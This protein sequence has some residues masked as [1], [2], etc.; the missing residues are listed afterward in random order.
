[1]PTQYWC[2]DDGIWNCPEGSDEANC[3]KVRKTMKANSVKESAGKFEDKPFKGQNWQKVREMARKSSTQGIR[4]NKF[5]SKPKY[6]YKLSSR[7]FGKKYSK[8]RVH[9]STVENNF[10]RTFM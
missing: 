3:G 4:P 1:M 8:K 6:W 7:K 9:V 5:S 10:W 2:D